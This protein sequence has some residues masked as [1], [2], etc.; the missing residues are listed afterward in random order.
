VKLSRL[1]GVPAVAG[2]AMCL[3]I[4]TPLGAA[5]AA[6]QTVVSTSSA[7]PSVEP[8]TPAEIAYCVQSGHLLNCLS[9]FRDASEALAQALRLFPSSLHNGAG[10][11]FMNC[12]WSAQ[13]TMHL[14]L[15]VARGFDERHEMDPTQ[16]AVEAQMDLQNDSTGRIVGYTAASVSSAKTSCAGLARAGYLWTVVD[17]KLVPPRS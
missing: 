15:P 12:F 6:K 14:G 8:P 16:P 5:H 7:G 2:A 9:S 13:M 10:D 4:S 11:A 3:S 1:L 17:G